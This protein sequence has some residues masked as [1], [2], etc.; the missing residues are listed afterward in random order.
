MWSKE[1]Q[2]YIKRNRPY[3]QTIAKYVS[4]V[5]HCIDPAAGFISAVPLR[6]TGMTEQEEQIALVY[7]SDVLRVLEKLS[8]FTDLF[9]LN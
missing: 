5:V 9:A 2:L 6:G 4:C 8:Y 7:P 3:E 1:N